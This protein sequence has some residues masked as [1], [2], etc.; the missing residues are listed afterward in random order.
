MSKTDPTKKRAVERG[1]SQW[2]RSS[3]FL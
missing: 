3:C 2:V 1:C